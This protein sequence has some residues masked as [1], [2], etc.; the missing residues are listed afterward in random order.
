MATIVKAPQSAGPQTVVTRPVAPSSHAPASNG[1]SSPTAQ[2]AAGNLAVQR[3]FRSGAIQAKLA[4]SQPGDP[5]ELEADQIADQVMRMPEPGSAVP[6][7]ACAA[8]D[9]PC[10]KCS[11]TPKIQRTARDSSGGMAVVTENP[12]RHLGS[13]QPLDRSTR[14][15]FEPRFGTALSHVRVHTDSSAAESARVIQA[16]AFTTGRDVVFGAGQFAPES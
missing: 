14:S 11:G 1:C 5:D 13:G 15:F 3:L 9:Q 16:R 10:P 12:L 7:A 2:Q 8:G 6:C 4:I